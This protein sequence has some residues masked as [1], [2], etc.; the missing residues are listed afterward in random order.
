[1]AW[2]RATSS[3]LW[4]GLGLVVNLDTRTVE[5]NGVPPMKAGKLDQRARIESEARRLARSGEYC[6]FRSIH[7]TLVA[8]GFEEAA[9]VFANRWTSSELDRLCEQ[10]LHANK[11]D[12]QRAA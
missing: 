11:A 2:M 7:L 6:S 5:V 12:P 10:A 3:S 1:M 4:N 9:K 8:R